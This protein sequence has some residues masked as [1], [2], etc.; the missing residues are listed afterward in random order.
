MLEEVLAKHLDHA[1]VPNKIALHDR[2]G[3][4][5]LEEVWLH[6]TTKIIAV[7][8][9]LHEVAFLREGE[10]S[11][12]AIC[13]RLRHVFPDDFSAGQ[14]ASVF[15]REALALKNVPFAVRHVVLHREPVGARTG[16]LDT[17]SRRKAPSLNCWGSSV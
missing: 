14:S 13:A 3:R 16:V 15:S 7:A 17:R 8:E 1:R 12:R 2:R 6:G 9:S 10:W 11:S 4:K 5:C